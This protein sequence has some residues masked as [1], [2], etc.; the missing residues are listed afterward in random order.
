MLETKNIFGR[1]LGSDDSIGMTECTGE[2]HIVSISP[3]LHTDE[4][5]VLKCALVKVNC[6]HI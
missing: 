3:V 5:T 6:I 2:M 4:R 1:L